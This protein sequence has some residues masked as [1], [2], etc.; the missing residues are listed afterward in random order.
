M[1]E[2]RLT[3]DEQPIPGRVLVITPFGKVTHPDGTTFDFDWLYEEIIR[4]TIE[5]AGMTPVRADEV[6]GPASVQGVVWRGIQQAELVVVDFSCR[7]PNVSLE[8]MAARIIGKRM[9]YLAQHPDDIPS[10]VRGLRYIPYAYGYAEMAAMQKELRVQLEAVRKEPSQEMALIPMATGGTVPVRGQIVSVSREF[11]VVRA[12]DGGHGVLGCE[13]VNWG[14][15]VHDM[16]RHYSVGDRVDGAFEMLP[17]GGT[18]Y[19]L[20]AGQPNPWNELASTHPVGRTFTGTVHSVRDAGVFVRISGPING[21]IPRGSLP[22]GAFPPPGGKVEVTVLAVDSRRRRVTLSLVG[23]GSQPA[24]PAGGVKTGDRLEG[25]IVKVR[26]EGEGGFVLL[27]VDG[28]RRPVFLHCT[29]MTPD[30]RHDLNAGG[31]EVG[32]LLDLEVTRVDPAGDKV[33]VRDVENETPEAP[34]LPAAA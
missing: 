23:T 24:G 6:Y 19:T 31:I 7:N 18:K 25:E 10:D 17:T 28:R 13:D 8:Y 27:K 5:E 16:T 4:T 3:R 33:F 11:A 34:G 14:R 12:D 2:I 21:L 22:E 15:I 9:I 20:L 30:L 32:E 1:H 29:A 26:P